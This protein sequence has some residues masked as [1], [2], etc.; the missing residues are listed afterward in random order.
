MIENNRLIIKN[1][2]ILF[3][4]L[5][6]TSTIGLFVSRFIIRSLGASDFGLYS[7]VGGIVIMMAFL[8]TVMIS[9]TYRFIA[10]EMGKGNK[11]GVNAVFNLSLVIHLCLAILILVISETAGIYYIKNY[12]NV[13]S[14]KI[15]DA[16]F[17]LRF[18]TY[19]TVIS[20]ISILQEVQL[21]TEKKTDSITW[22]NML[23]L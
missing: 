22:W 1:S 16:L 23:N 3:F 21:A 5:L 8:N 6:I 9:T 15:P 10:V 17:V 4:R 11:E 19:A 13:A 20:I 2:G 14:D 12:L 18:S 7:V